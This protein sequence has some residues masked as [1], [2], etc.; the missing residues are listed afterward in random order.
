ME[1]DMSTT[2]ALTRQR[3]FECLIP[4]IS[5]LLIVLFFSYIDEG[6][7][8]FRWVMDPG[9]CIAF[10]IY[11]AIFFAI[12]SLIY[13]FALSSLKGISKIIIMFG[14]VTPGVV[15]LILSLVF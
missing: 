7:Y 9:S 14:V 5:A 1:I 13:N 11:M 6:N 10:G 15:A 8:D 3:N 2:K 12:K 4:F